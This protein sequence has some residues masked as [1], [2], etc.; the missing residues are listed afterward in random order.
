VTERH[1]ELEALRSELIAMAAADLALRA[2]LASSGALFEGYH[3]R[4]RALHETNAARLSAILDSHG[5]PGR[6]LVG[7]EAAEAAWLILQ[8]AIGDPALQRRG[9]ALLQSAA[10]ANDVAPAHVATLEDRIRASEGRPQRYGTQFDWD[11]RGS[12][13]PL[14]IEDEANVDARRAAVGLCPLAE[15]IER[16]RRDAAAAGEHAPKDWQARQAEIREWRRATGWS[17]R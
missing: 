12:V 9:L 5:W 4:M 11:E 8:H 2:E 7:D 16:M 10:A 15:Q 17:D 13:S 14:P 6:S 3:P 1:P